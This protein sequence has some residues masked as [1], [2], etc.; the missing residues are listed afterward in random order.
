MSAKT[1]PINPQ[2][3]AEMFRKLQQ[4]DRENEQLRIRLANAQASIESRNKLIRSL[5]S[6]GRLERDKEQREAQRR[7]SDA[8]IDWRCGND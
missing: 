8:V 3:H 2:V 6:G 4:L 5:Q 1:L 7:A